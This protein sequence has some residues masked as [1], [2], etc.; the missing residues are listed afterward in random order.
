MVAD[1]SL[2]IGGHVLPSP[3]LL[4]S[5]DALVTADA[6]SLCVK[7]CGSALGGLVTKS[8]TIEPRAGYP[9]PR[10]ARVGDGILVASGNPNPGISAMVAHVSHF[11]RSHEMVFLLGSIVSDPDNPKPTLEEEYA[12]LAREYAGAGVS[13]LELNLSCP[14]LDPAEK[15][16]T[17]VPAQ[18]P[19][20]VSR[21]VR[22]VKT[23]LGNS[24]FS[25][26][27][28]IP[29]LTGWNCDPVA[30][31]KAASSAG[32]DAITISNL[33]PGTAYFTGIGREQKAAQDSLR[34]GQYRVANRKGGLSGRAMHPAVL[35]M[36]ESL[37]NHVDIPIIGTGGC[38]SDLDTLVQTFMAGATAIEAVTPFY[39]CDT[40]GLQ[41]LDGISGLTEELRQFLERLGLESPSD[42]YRLRS[43][44]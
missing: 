34:L 10:T 30:V 40:E 37:R 4:G 26:C 23:E 44:Q 7:R 16:R 27:L 32:A 12:M 24:G 25:K 43:K 8:T 28:V 22:A 41:S 5:F 13:G 33:F 15:E 18:D 29:K 38:A 20:K 11:R 9:E 35:L 21:I 39:F 14:H 17:I 31:A 36:I 19:E 3:L 1:I 6:L 42:L 2:T